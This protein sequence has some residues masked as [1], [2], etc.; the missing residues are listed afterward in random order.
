M[1]FLVLIS[2]VLR[3]ELF[4]KGL[5]SPL[6][7]ICS[8]SLII[9]LPVTGKECLARIGKFGETKF[10]SD[11]FCVV[12]CKPPAKEL[13]CSHILSKPVLAGAAIGPCKWLQVD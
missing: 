2:K 9:T 1:V 6:F 5:V 8:K 3:K 13:V 10:V 7:S 4:A 11:Y 12:T